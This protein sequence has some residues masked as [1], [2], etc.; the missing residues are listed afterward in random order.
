[1]VHQFKTSLFIT[2]LLAFQALAVVQWS[3]PLQL[4]PITNASIGFG[5]YM[6]PDGSKSYVLYTRPGQQLQQNQPPIQQLGVK[7]FI[8][9]SK[10]LTEFVRLSDSRLYFAGDIKGDD[11]GAQLLVAHGSSR[12]KVTETPPQNASLFDIFLTYSMN[13]G[14]SWN[15]EISISQAGS[16]QAVGHVMP[17]IVAVDE[18]GQLFIFYMNVYPTNM[19]ALATMKFS[20]DFSTSPPKEDIIFQ[21]NNPIVGFSAA[22]TFANNALKLHVAWVV[23]D[24]SIMYSNSANGVD[25]SDPVKLGQSSNRSGSLVSLFSDTKV[26]PAKLYLT[27]I[28][29]DDL[30]YVIMSNDSGATWST[31]FVLVNTKTDTFTPVF[32]G[33]QDKQAILFL[34]SHEGKLNF[35]IYDLALGNV[36]TET[37]PFPDKVMIGQF[38]QCARAS[39]KYTV[40]VMATDFAAVS[41]YVTAAEISDV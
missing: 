19:T 17:S 20:A 21:S 27:Y 26:E 11:T 8:S 13:G 5:L 38:L 29:N 9:A 12:V 35:G 16:D 28:A 25:W 1:M 14:S 30:P 34:A 39:G 6:V 7:Q 22:Y 32:C 3:T 41:G 31:P 4:D 15:N 23:N 40:H 33:A 24:T 18:L 36:K 10:T 37:S 2:A